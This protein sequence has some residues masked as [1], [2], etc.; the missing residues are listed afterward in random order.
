VIQTRVSNGVVIQGNVLDPQVI[1]GRFPLIIADPPY[2]EILNEDWDDWGYEEYI[3]LAHLIR[4]ALT[5][6]GSAYVWGGI[7]K[8]E[9]R[10]FFKF[11]ANVEEETGLNLR[12]VITWGKKRAYGKKDDYLFTREEIA[13]LVKGDKPA[14]FNIPLLDER[15]GYAGY[16]PKYPAK[17]EYKRR[18]NVWS[19]ITEVLRGK[20]H[21]A[22]K[23]ERLAE[24]MIETH[25]NPGDTV[26]DLFSGSGNVSVVAARL[27][28]RFV[29][30]EGKKDTFGKIVER[31]AA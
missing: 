16:N 2:G 15:R 5:D 24:I 7:G 27:G 4:G 20:K 17:S 3:H 30:V 28:R 29:A 12:N 31:L 22:E 13:W 1:S 23:P 9:K 26:L 10:I 6:G 21:R 19:D 11:L 25:T 8:R 18:T 14:V